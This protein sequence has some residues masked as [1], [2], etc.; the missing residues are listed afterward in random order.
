MDIVYLRELAIETVIGAFE[1]ERDIKQT[2]ILDLEMATDIRTAAA[3]DTLADALDYKAVSKRLIEFVGASRFHLVET[4]AERCA[5]LV[6]QEFSVAWL[7]LRVNKRGA[8]RHAVDVG[9]VI[10]RGYR[11]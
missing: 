8:L 6:M 7:R 2:I 9:V 3:T 1:W 5:E 10:E 11:G 4:L